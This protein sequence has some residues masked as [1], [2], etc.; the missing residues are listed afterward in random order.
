MVKSKQTCKK[1]TGGTAPKIALLLPAS[2]G[3]VTVPGELNVREPSEHNEFCLI[4]RDG[5]VGE[6]CLFL[7]STCLRVMCSNCMNIPPASAC[8]VQAD[9]VTF[10]CI[11]CHVG[12]ER[13]GHASQLPYFGFYRKG[14]PLLPSFLQIRATLEVSLH[15][16]LSSAPT[17]MLHLILVDHDVTGGCFE[18]ASKFLRPYFPSRGFEFWSIAFDISNASKIDKYRLQATA[19]V[20]LLMSSNW[21]RVIVAITNHTDNENGDPF[22]GYK[23]NKK[24]YISAR[25]HSVLDVLLSPWHPLIHGAAESYLWLFSCG[26]LIN[27]VTSFSGLQQAVIDHRIT[28][29]IGFNASYK[30]GRHTDVFLL[31]PDNSGSLAVTKFAWTHSE[32]RPWINIAGSS[33]VG[34]PVVRKIRRALLAAQD[35]QEEPIALPTSLKKAIKEYYA[36]SLKDKEEADKREAASRQRE[37]SFYKKPLSEWDVAQK[38]FK[39]EIDSYDKAQQQSK[40]LEYSI[41]YRTGNAREWFNNMT[42][43]QQQEVKFAM[44]KWNEEGAPEETQAIYSSLTLWLEIS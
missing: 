9:D 31:M 16:Q 24:L 8:T 12:M 23:G 19:I 7:C 32:L 10:V 18:L 22:I 21:A 13:H 36:K 3:A 27:N 20:Q 5:S 11:S 41:K 30:L 17:L 14:Q 28:A 2:T 29:T 38:L 33:S 40:G 15:S 25:V 44:K 43:S 34:K 37:P 4:C 39:Q 42:P 1:S 6:D 35:E 26:T